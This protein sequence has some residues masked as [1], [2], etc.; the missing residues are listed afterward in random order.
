MS[1]LP[2]N[3]DGIFEDGPQ[4]SQETMEK[5]MKELATFLKNPGISLLLLTLLVDLGFEGQFST[6]GISEQAALAMDKPTLQR[7]INE[8]TGIV[9]QYI[10]QKEQET[11]KNNEKFFKE[12]PERNRILF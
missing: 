7:L 2:E 1:L 3:R 5:T 11:L 6:L 12:M 9:D 10:Q 8:K 4:Y